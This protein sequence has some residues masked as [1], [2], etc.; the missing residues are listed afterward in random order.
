MTAGR[1]ST[2]LLAVAL[3][4]AVCLLP[5][6]ASARRN[7]Y[8]GN[9]ANC[10]KDEM[11]TQVAISFTPDQF[12]PGA[13][14]RVRVDVSLEGAAVAGFFLTSGG[15]GELIP[16]GGD[17]RSN[18]T[19]ATHTEPK[20]MSGGSA[21]FELDWQA[22][23]DPRG[24]HFQL[25]GVGANGNN[26]SGGDAAAVPIAVDR[27]FGCEGTL[28]YRDFDG[29]GYGTDLV[30]PLLDCAAPLGYAP[31][32]NDC[33]EDDAML[34]PGMTEVCNMKDDDCDTRI[35]EFAAPHCGVGLCMRYA[36]YCDPNAPCFPGE[37]MPEMCNGLD[38]DCDGVVDQGALCTGDLVCHQ[39]VCKTMDEALAIDPNFVPFEGSDPEPVGQGGSAGTS[40]GGTS[41]G[42]MSG[43]A[44]SSMTPLGGSSAGLAGSGGSVAVGSG[45]MTSSAA[46]MASS[47][48]APAVPEAAAGC[49]VARRFA[50]SSWGWLCLL[51]L[52][53]LALHA[54][55]QAYVPVA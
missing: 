17:T 8:F 44:G 51:A 45:G 36:E 22:P 31:L 30:P 19:Q 29:D 14:V 52:F 28:F 46:G 49:G 41:S 38:E 33:S 50:M 11:G 18:G 35:D 37:P 2:R 3:L 47:N 12:E 53:G 6:T 1:P 15:V 7:G 34:N 32:N 40:S 42:G 27:I 26:N 48:T 4:A 5:G 25:Y 13:L 23:N 9:C 16:V 43:A 24:V 21:S 39:A 54:R 10:H 20:G 55:R